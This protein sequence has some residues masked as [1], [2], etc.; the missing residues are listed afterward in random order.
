MKMLNGGEVSTIL[1]MFLALVL[2]ADAISAAIR[3]LLA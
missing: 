3:R 2:L 1:I